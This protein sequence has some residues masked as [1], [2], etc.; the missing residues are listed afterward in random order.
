[1]SKNF[2]PGLPEVLVPTGPVRGG[3]II[4]GE[5]NYL[6]VKF[7]PVAFVRCSSASASPP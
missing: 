6:I 1:M 3:W 2:V 5:R 4:L 7:L